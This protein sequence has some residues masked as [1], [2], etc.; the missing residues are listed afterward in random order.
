MATLTTQ[1]YEELRKKGLSD[2][3]IKS[4]AASKGFSLEGEGATG[5][6]GVAVGFGKGLLRTARGTAQLAQSAGQ[7]ILAALTPSSLEDVQAQ[8]GF[9]SLKETSP[10]GA[11]ITQQLKAKTTEE[12][13]GGIA[14]DV[15]LFF[16]P[17]SK[18]TQVA[19]RITQQ[20]G[21]GTAKLGIGISAKEAPLIQ[22]YKAKF[23]LGSRIS[24]ALT[25]KASLAPTTAR[26]TALRQGLFGTESQIGIQAKRGATNLWQQVIQPQLA[27][28]KVTIKMS[29]F[30]DEIGKEIGK[31]ADPARQRALREALDAFK[32]DY[33]KVGKINLEKLQVFKE[34]WAKFLPEK[35]YKGKPIAGA[36]KEIQNIA[37]QLARN[38][39]YGAFD[40]VGIKAA[41]LDYGNLK[42]LQLLG[43]KAMQRAKFKGGAGSFVSGVASEVLTPIAT[44]AGL[45]LYRAGKGLEFVGTK[46]LKVV[47]QIFGL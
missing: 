34:A 8:T 22:A 15:A 6:G 14:A 26:E 1:Q 21:R 33:A 42:N 43:Q 30:I 17:T 3:S 45:T 9:E 4:L 44:T 40:D 16:V 5:L 29:S 7:G 13:I 25:G 24:S 23:S 32:V 2:A 19:G 41:Y 47:S 20:A 36:F 28:S 39:I 10:V 31:I 18:A 38:K 12:K 27:S 37:A 46:G 35:V 11:E